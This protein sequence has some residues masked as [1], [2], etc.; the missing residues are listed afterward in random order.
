MPA[1]APVERTPTSPSKVGRSGAFKKASAWASEG[2]FSLG[3][4]D[5]T[6]EASS[7]QTFL[8]AEAS[9]GDG[10]AASRFFGI[11]GAMGLE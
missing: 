7:G 10:D 11:F 6:T 8:A 1:S 5:G 2:G 4:K 3:A 9:K